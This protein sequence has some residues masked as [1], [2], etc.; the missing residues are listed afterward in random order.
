MINVGTNEFRG[1]NTNLLVLG[2][3]AT[4]LYTDYDGR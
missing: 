1:G 2:V 4:D 3:S